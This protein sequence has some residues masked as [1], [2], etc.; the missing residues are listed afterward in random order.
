MIPQTLTEKGFAPY[1]R[2]LAVPDW[3]PD[4]SA[5]A[6]DFWRGIALIAGE[7]SLN[8]LR[9]KRRA[10]VFD[11]MERHNRSPEAM[12][13]L[14]GACLLPVAPAG[15]LEPGTVG[16]FRMNPGDA[17]VL[18]QGCWHWVPFPLGESSTIVVVFTASTPDEDVEVR[19]LGT[20]VEIEV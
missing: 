12:I 1:G 18:D 8:I 20:K 17:V 10:F 2:I 7:T 14:S 6:Y 5:E 16:L 19:P 13:V 15:P 4:G 11:R 9:A 3:R